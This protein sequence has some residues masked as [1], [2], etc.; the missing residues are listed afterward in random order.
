V[1]LTRRARAVA[2]ARR[3]AEKWHDILLF[4]G[5]GLVIGGFVTDVLGAA[6]VGIALMA[7]ELG[8]RTTE[9]DRAYME[10]F[11]DGLTAADTLATL[12]GRPAQDVRRLPDGP[13]LPA[14]G[15]PDGRVEPRQRPHREPVEVPLDWDALAGVALGDRPARPLPGAFVDEPIRTGPRPPSF[16]P[17]A[18]ADIRNL[19]FGGNGTDRTSA[20]G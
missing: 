8:R 18:N 9:P 15:A 11:T 10:G 14:P 7:Y 12:D 4:V 1:A 16:P 6:S 2:S 3:P 13:D 17:V 20:G 5:A 19:S